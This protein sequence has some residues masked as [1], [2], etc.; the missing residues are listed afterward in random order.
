M[1]ISWFLRYEIEEVPFLEFF[2]FALPQYTS[3]PHFSRFIQTYK[4]LTLKA[5][6]G[7]RGGRREWQ[8]KLKG[9]KGKRRGD[10]KGS[11]QSLSALWPGGGT[12]WL[13]SR[14]HL[15]T[16]THTVSVGLCAEHHCLIYPNLCLTTACR[17][18]YNYWGYGWLVVFKI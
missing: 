6:R 7:E 17:L 16:H 11:C 4:S 2:S 15:H 12:E 14:H 3:I 10:T 5:L 9:K 18:N 1:T 13:Y 8:E